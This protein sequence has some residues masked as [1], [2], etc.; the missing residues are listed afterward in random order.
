VLDAND[1]M[2]LYTTIGN[3]LGVKHKDGGCDRSGIDC[4]CFVQMVYD[5]VYQKKLPR[6]SG[7]M[8]KYAV[9]V[10]TTAVKEGDLVF[11]TIK[12]RR[13]SHV[14]IVL[15][16]KWFVHVSS[17]KGV[18]INHLSEAYYKKYLTGAGKIR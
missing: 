9:S 1:N 3:W 5:H 8:F 18:A 11:F 7:E 4:S 2:Q 17:T 16:N 13:V 10:D 6:S 12:A 14:G 15:K